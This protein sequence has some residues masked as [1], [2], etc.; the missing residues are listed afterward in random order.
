M[1]DFVLGEFGEGERGKAREL[2][3]RGA[4][5]LETALEKDL[6]AAMNRFNTK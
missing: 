4:K 1:D 2:V 3:K 5:A 6:Q